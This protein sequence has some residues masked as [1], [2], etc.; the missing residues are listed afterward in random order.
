MA[1]KS[2]Q[3]GKKID[4][5]CLVCG[6]SFT[7]SEY[8]FNKGRGKYCSRDC[9][10]EHLKKNSKKISVICAYCGEKFKTYQFNLDRGGGIYC[11]KD[12][13]NKTLPGRESPM[14]GKKHNKEVREKMSLSQIGMVH[15]LE[16][17]L[18]QST[19]MRGE[20]NHFWEGGKTKEIYPEGWNKILKNIIRERDDYI[21]QME[22]CG[23]HQ[24]ELSCKLDVHHIDYNK[25]NI[26][27]K[28]LISLCR[29]CHIKTNCNRD[30]W[31]NYFN[32]E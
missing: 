15:T 5:N 18:K 21:C 25:D 22:G 7:V 2:Y 32:K 8:R 12:C 9:F 4:V 14:K 13:F 28:N 1:S 30:Y 26:D 27:P 24:D 23:I 10:Y 20:R 16:R 3:K 19:R 29:S 31:L 11:S 17:R 6:E